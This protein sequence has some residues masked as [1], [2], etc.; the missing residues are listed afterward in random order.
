MM[1]D[2]LT[3]VMQFNDFTS[4]TPTNTRY[5]GD[6]PP[7]S[8]EPAGTQTDFYRTKLLK[9]ETERLRAL[10]AAAATA[11]ADVAGD[12]D[13]DAAREAQA[14]VQEAT[15]VLRT[16]NFTAVPW[17]GISDTGLVTLQWQRDEEGVALFSPAMEFSAYQQRQAPTTIIRIIGNGR[18][19]TVCPPQS[20]LKSYD[21]RLSG[22]NRPW[23]RRLR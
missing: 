23:Q 18:R 17:I 5:D 2:R 16:A 1:P 21:Y 19:Q 10:S 12:L 7:I 13:A 14:A 9:E 11:L 6:H 15:A 8:T 22:A 20:V 3:H 4:V